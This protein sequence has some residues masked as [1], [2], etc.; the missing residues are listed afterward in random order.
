VL[1]ERGLA[2]VEITYVSGWHTHEKFVAPNAEHVRAARAKLPP[3]HRAH[4]RVIFTA[5]SIPIEMAQ[6]SKYEQQ[7]LETSREVARAA[8]VD[9]WVLVYQSRS[10]R[11]QDPWLEPDISDYLR[12]AR[13]EGLEAAVLCPIGFLCD[14]IEVLYDLD[15]EA[16]DVANEIGLAITRAEAVN[17]NPQFIDMLADVVLSTLRRYATG[18]PLPIAHARAIA[19]ASEQRA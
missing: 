14:H 3:E 10:G 11:P 9:D 4:A 8:Q 6:R 5:H 7:L 12:A 1:R 15:R 17:D 16:A 18:R 13:A 19:P 2:D